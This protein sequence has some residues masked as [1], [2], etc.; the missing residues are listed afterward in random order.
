MGDQT[1]AIRGDSRPVPTRLSRAERTSLVRLERVV[2][3]GL[4]AFVA[5]GEALLEIRDRGL[6]RES[7]ATFREYLAVRWQLSRSRGYQL[8]DAAQVSGALSTAVDLEPPANE[9]QARALV[10]LRDDEEALVETWRKLRDRH[11]KQ[12]NAD[13]VR[14][15]VE[16]RLAREAFCRQPTTTTEP[17]PTRLPKVWPRSRRLGV[18]DVGRHRIMCGD[19]TNGDE[20]KRLMGRRRAALLFTSPPYADLRRFG[21]DQDLAVEHIAEFI[22]LFSERADLLVVNL[23]LI[24]RKSAVVRYWDV[25]LAAAEEAA[26]PL[27]AW[28][29]WDKG[30]GGAHPSGGFFP[31]QHEW[32][33]CFGRSPRPVFR[34]V[35]NASAGTITYNARRKRDG[36]VRKSPPLAVRSR[37]AIGSVLSLSQERANRLLGHPAPFP[38]ALPTAY[39]EALTEPGDVVVDPFLGSGS[40][41]VACELTGRRCLGLELEPRF[42]DLARARHAALGNARSGS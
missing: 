4:E 11:G 2:E 23:G 10:P 3:K 38:V 37:R 35:E 39:I 17:T 40:T 18:Y 14:A 33:F 36:V 24:R 25:F 12:L 20:V 42:C 28:N 16:E 5:V 13:L 6:Y 27:L 34:T 41:L 26:L 21:A 8:I 30:A 29:V 15:A 19:A 31:P 22:P 32:V 9:A 1:S 7:H